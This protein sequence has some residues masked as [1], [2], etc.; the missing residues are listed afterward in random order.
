MDGQPPFFERY[1][2]NSA[3]VVFRD[4]DFFPDPHI[5]KNEKRDFKIQEKRKLD[6]KIEEIMIPTQNETESPSEDK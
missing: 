6:F 3:S 2:I 4:W 1:T 5:K